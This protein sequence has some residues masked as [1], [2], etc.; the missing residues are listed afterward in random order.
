MV[1]LQLDHMLPIG[2]IFIYDK[3]MGLGNIQILYHS[4]E[5]VWAKLVVKSMYGKIWLIEEIGLTLF[6]SK[7]QHMSSMPLMT[8]SGGFL[9]RRKLLQGPKGQ[10]F[11]PHRN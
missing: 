9:K 4:M 2:M 8:V 6:I 7:F 5:V 10:C 3:D 11:R 1:S